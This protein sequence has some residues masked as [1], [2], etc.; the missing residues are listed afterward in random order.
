M[1]VTALMQAITK[2]SIDVVVLSVVIMALGVTSVTAL[3]YA[4]E[5]QVIDAS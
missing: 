3:S 4:A 5:N 1:D 2:F